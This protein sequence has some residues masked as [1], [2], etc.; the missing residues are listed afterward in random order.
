MVK[1]LGIVG[2]ITSIMIVIIWSFDKTRSKQHF[3]QW[4]G[5]IGLIGSITIIIT[6][7]QP[8][9]SVCANNAV[10]LDNTDG[11]NHVCAW[12]S[13][14]FSY[15][16]FGTVIAWTLQCLDV[17][18]KICWGMKTDNY[19][20]KYMGLTFLGPFIPIIAMASL[21]TWG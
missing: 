8:Y 5:I 10:P 20:N 7:S 2:L 17:H 3:V 6:I 12:T 21:G 11:P 16:V 1:V 13:F 19:K 9:D 14:V 18:L 4:F 15:C